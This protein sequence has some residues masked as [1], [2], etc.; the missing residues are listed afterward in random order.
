M[1]FQADG[2]TQ[3]GP[4]V[5]LSDMP[6]EPVRPAPAPGERGQ[7]ILAEFGVTAEEWQRLQN[8]GVV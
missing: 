5:R 6:A 3:Y 1:G 2:I 8:L 7:A 4:P